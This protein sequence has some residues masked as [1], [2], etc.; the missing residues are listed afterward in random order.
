MTL[1]YD[2]NIGNTF[3]HVWNYLTLCVTNGIVL[4]ES[5]FQFCKDTVEFAGL[6]ITPTGVS[7]T[8]T[9]LNAIQ[10]L[11]QP[12]DIKGG[13]SWFGL[14]N[15]VTCEYSISPIMQPFH[16]LVKTN[17]KFMWKDTLTQILENSRQIL[18]LANKVKE[19]IQLFDV[20]QKTYLQ[21]DWSKESIGYLL[22]HCN[23]P[24]SQAPTCCTDG[25]KLIFSVLIHQ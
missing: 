14:I 13:Q 10:K 21:T 18:I 16:E 17:S 15:Q 1:L 24:T 4:N 7:P 2:T 23:C 8:D 12:S 22:Q 6:K 5:K 20:T 25:W 9:I 19:G 11:P 3:F